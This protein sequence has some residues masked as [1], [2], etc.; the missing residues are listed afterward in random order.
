MS[1]PVILSEVQSRHTRRTQDPPAVTTLVRD[2]KANIEAIR[3]CTKTLVR[4]L[5][6]SGTRSVYVEL[7]C[8]SSRM[9]QSPV[10]TFGVPQ[11]A[12][13]CWHPLPRG[14]VAVLLAPA[15]NK[16]QDQHLHTRTLSSQ[17]PLR[18]VRSWL[19]SR[20]RCGFSETR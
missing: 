7:S 8:A 5:R 2:Q 3:L 12:G 15:F 14:G 17:F 19:L 10:R 1:E 9:R 18:T 20:V 6:L 4:Q 11:L 13:D 16:A